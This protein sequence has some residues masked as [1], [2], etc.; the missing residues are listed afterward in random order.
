MNAL[1]KIHSPAPAADPIFGLIA[2]HRR[3][4]KLAH[5]GGRDD[6]DG[7]ATTAECDF[8]HD[9]LGV[10]PETIPGLLAWLDYILGPAGYED[11]YPEEFA[12]IRGTIK[13]FGEA[14]QG[15]EGAR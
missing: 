11:A 6:E 4:F 3:L 9:L 5:G 14:L 13:R 12:T 10:A 15:R 7:V 1:P 2:E 8:M